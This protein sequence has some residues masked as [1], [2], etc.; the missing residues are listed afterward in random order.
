MLRRRSRQHRRTCPRPLIGSRHT[1]AVGDPV[2]LPAMP[3]CA[4]TW[5]K[6]NGSRS[7]FAFYSELGSLPVPFGCLSSQ[8]EYG[9]SF[10]VSAHLLNYILFGTTRHVLKRSRW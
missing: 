3:G 4:H 8:P 7:P 1:V 5:P 10:M 2:C 6:A 9:L